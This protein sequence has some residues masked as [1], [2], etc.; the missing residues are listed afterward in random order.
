MNDIKALIGDWDMTKE[1]I[2]IEEFKPY[3]YQTEFIKKLKNGKVQ[4]MIATRYRWKADKK[5]QNHE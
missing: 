5:I 4:P 3:P 1:P 2:T